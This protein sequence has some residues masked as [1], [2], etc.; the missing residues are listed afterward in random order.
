MTS[1]V[2]NYINNQ[3]EHHSKKSFKEEYIEMLEKYK[4]DY[5]AKYLFEWIK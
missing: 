2:I 1:A 4:I 5:D 3:E